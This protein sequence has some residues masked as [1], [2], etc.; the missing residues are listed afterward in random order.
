MK[1]IIL[2]L[3]YIIYRYI[4]YN[5]DWNVKYSTWQFL[6]ILLQF[7]SRT[8]P[9]IDWTIFP[10]WYK[11]IVELALNFKYTAA[12][13]QLIQMENYLLYIYLLSKGN[14]FLKQCFTLNSQHT[15]FQITR[16]FLVFFYVTSN[17]LLNLTWKKKWKLFQD[18]I[19]IILRNLQLIARILKFHTEVQFNN[20]NKYVKFQLINYNRKFWWFFFFFYYQTNWARKLKLVRKVQIIIN[21]CYICRKKNSKSLQSN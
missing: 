15:S 5:I 13:F 6:S 17:L 12:F 2:Y 16:I 10:T 14:G 7:Y 3:P 18:L 1:K 19:L 4:P 21:L 9:C 11:E 8:R 20:T